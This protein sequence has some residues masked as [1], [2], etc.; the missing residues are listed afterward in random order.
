M[1][2]TLTRK[3][4]LKQLTL[5]LGGA[6][7]AGTVHA[8]T[9]VEVQFYFPV[10]VGGAIAKMMDGFSDGFMKEQPRHQGHADLRRHLPGDHRQGADRA[11]VGQRRRRPRCCCPPTCSR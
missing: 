10:A 3:T 4:F 2:R 8:Q 9:P 1:T 7:L 5:G 11:Q 6:L